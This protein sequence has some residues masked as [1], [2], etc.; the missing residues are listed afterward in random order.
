MKYLNFLHL[1]VKF[2]IFYSLFNKIWAVG[3]KKLS[4]LE[5]ELSQNFQQKSWAELWRDYF[6]EAGNFFWGGE[7]VD[8]N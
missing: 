7:G 3:N 1:L 5:N 2:S 4:N 8:L 6:V